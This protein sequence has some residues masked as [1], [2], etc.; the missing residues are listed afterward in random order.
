MGL[1]VLGDVQVMWDSQKRSTPGVG[2]VM[3]LCGGTRRVLKSRPSPR[4]PKGAEK[5][6]Y[7]NM[8][9]QSANDTL[10]PC[11]LARGGRGPLRDSERCAHSHHTHVTRVSAAAETQQTNKLIHDAKPIPQVYD[12]EVIRTQRTRHTSFA[13]SINHHFD[14]VSSSCL[15]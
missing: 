14:L 3:R 7:E 15:L 9:K 5:I 6:R 10:S 4:P 11:Y 12:D 8:R 13:V 2:P 1:W